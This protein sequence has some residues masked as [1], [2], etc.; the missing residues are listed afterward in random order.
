[1]KFPFH[2]L[3][4]SKVTLLEY[5]FSTNFIGVISVKNTTLIAEEYMHANS[6]PVKFRTE[7]PNPLTI[8]PTENN[9]SLEQECNK[10][11][12]VVLRE[13]RIHSTS[14]EFPEPTSVINPVCQNPELVAQTNRLTLSGGMVA[15]CFKN[16]ILYP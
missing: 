11:S 1:M 14:K 4:I 2:R 9:F 15:V 6:K 12:N 8:H 3:E 13:N 10:S 7:S 5:I 16:V